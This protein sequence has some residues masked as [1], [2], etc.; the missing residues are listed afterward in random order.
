MDTSTALLGAT[1]LDG[2]TIG[3]AKTR[4]WL[5]EDQGRTIDESVLALTFQLGME[6]GVRLEKQKQKEKEKWEKLY[7]EA[8]LKQP[9]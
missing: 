8:A 3:Q 6:Q 5:R 7:Q 4:K 2:D 9:T 1:C